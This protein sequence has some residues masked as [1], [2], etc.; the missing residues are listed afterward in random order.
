MVK[1]L[2]I[3]RGIS[4]SGKTTLAKKIAAFEN[5]HFYEADMFFMVEGEYKFVPPKLKLAHEYCFG[6]VRKNIL[7]GK[8]VVVSNTFTREWEMQEYIHLALLYDYHVSIIECRG[9]YQNTHG[10]DEAAVARQVARFESNE[11]ILASN[12]RYQI[13][14]KEHRVSFVNYCEYGYWTYG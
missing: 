13:Y 9:R 10:L 6:Q 8:D 11:A 4:G 7:V 2:Y 1:M 12:E 3:V 5:C 14:T